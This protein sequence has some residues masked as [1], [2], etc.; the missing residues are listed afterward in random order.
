MPASL[1]YALL[2][3]ILWLTACGLDAPPAQAYLV[4]TR[5]DESDLTTIVILDKESP[6][7]Q[8]KETSSRGIKIV[9]EGEI[10][11]FNG[12]PVTMNKQRTVAAIHFST[13]TDVSQVYLVIATAKGNPKLIKDFNQQV[14]HLCERRHC[15]VDDVYQHVLRIHGRYLTVRAGRSEFSEDVYQ[16][17]LKVSKEGQLELIDCHRVTDTR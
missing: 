4:V 14:A 3:L 16:I 11:D 2:G 10:K 6:T 5:I 13:T 15:E 17:E 12:R 1:K 7:G 8:P 9:F